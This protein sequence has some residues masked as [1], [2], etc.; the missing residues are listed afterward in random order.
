MISLET[1]VELCAS[2]IDL[3]RTDDL[4]RPEYTGWLSSSTGIIR[5]T[6]IMGCAN[7]KYHIEN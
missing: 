1:A 6:L 5:A 7:G 4:D 2:L 3:P